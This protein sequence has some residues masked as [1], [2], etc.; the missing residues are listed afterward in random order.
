MNRLGCKNP[1]LLVCLL[2]ACATLTL[3]WPVHTH[4]FV[5]YDDWDY[6]S[7]NPHLRAGVSKDAIHW[8]F[9][10][11]SGANT[12]WHPLT[13]MSHMLDCQLFGVKPGPHHLV[14][15]FFH[16]VNVLLL[17]L[18]LNRMT[19]AFW[20]SALVAALFA[21]HPLQI[22]TV[23]WI[24]ERKNLLSVFFVL[25]C[26]AAYQRY[27]RKRSLW[28]YL[29]V[30]FLFCLA[31][32][33]KALV[34]TLPCLLLVLDFWPLR[35]LSL[36]NLSSKTSSPEAGGRQPQIHYPAASLQFLILE[37]LPLFIP[38]AVS[39]YLMILKH[40]LLGEISSGETL[41]LGARICNALVS[42]MRYCGKTIWPAHLAVYYPHPGWW[43]VWQ[44]AVAIAFLSGVSF[45]VLWS[46]RSRPYLLA[47]WL[48]F[49]GSLVPAIGIVQAGLQSMADR[50]FYLPA[51]GLLIMLVWGMA[52]LF[53]RWPQGKLLL[54]T[55]SAASL[56][57]ASLLTTR[58]LRH[59]QNTSTL[60]EHDLAVAG[61]NFIAR[62]IL[63][64]V[65]FAKGHYEEALAH[66]RKAVDLQPANYTGYSGIALV[67][68]AQGKFA[69]AIPFSQK[70]LA[71]EPAY[72]DAHAN[73]GVSFQKLGRLAEAEEQLREA[74]RLAPDCAQSAE[75]CGRL[76]IVLLQQGK[77][78]Q[79]LPLFEQSLRADPNNLDIRAQYISL[80]LKQGSLG[81]A[82][83]QGQ[84]ALRLAP[85]SPDA[86]NNYG[87]ALFAQGSAEQ[88]LVCFQKALQLKPGFPEAHNNCGIALAA[89][90]G[91]DQA[92]P[93]FKE[94]V[95]V[96]P[97]FLD[98]HSRLIQAFI[99][100][101]RINEAVA[102]YRQL[103]RQ[104][105]ESAEV[106]NNLAW[107]LATYP[108]PAIRNGTEAV[109]WAQRACAAN[110]HSF[111]FLDTLG[112]A[113]AEA[114]RFAEAASTVQKAITLGQTA[115]QTNAVARFRSRL[116][117]Y[118]A[119][120]PYHEP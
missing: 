82:V 116:E 77:L 81:Q 73:L 45:L 117:L 4:E 57:V 37:K 59:W 93:H 97:D 80:L 7:K 120:K 53:A 70:A 90:G 27:A 47:G 107:I 68:N 66:L 39:C 75:F 115:D 10:S 5:N 103:L 55:L 3:Y 1:T 24:A 51:I 102:E 43:P 49:L 76:A 25:L 105:P 17:F 23:A 88:A 8:A 118:Q 85:E 101:G 12:Y 113:Y 22:D 29:P 54:P 114:G 104:P 83:A 112:A 92:I 94:A 6:V 18:V 64:E 86:L 19:C 108:D 61:D 119:G 67:L 65:C 96:K 15:A 78:D 2:L 40:Q 21:S 110:P 9:S 48:W 71:I 38:V 32:M 62:N 14:S 44:V 100:E 58:Q 79:A 50:F 33:S 109:Q 13:W 84:T 36:S 30:F 60:F 63:A 74:V 52:E 99:R 26:L 69:E 46:A 98:A 91:F 28:R 41:P 35:R 56:L 34:V 20:R 95:R 11:I 89:Q 106:M 31:L 87:A 72:P 111:S 42:Y 16:T